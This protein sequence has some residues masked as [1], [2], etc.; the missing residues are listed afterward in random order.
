ME[1]DEFSILNSKFSIINYFGIMVNVMEPRVD[2]APFFA[3]QRACMAACSH[4]RR[5]SRVAAPEA[6][7]VTTFPSASTVI[8][9]V[10]VVLCARETS[11]SGQPRN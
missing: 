3:L 10:T 1:N 4:L 11:G 5:I 6:V 7:A 8:E 2:G 9:T